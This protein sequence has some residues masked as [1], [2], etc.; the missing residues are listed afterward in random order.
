M[1][2][3]YPAWWTA[4]RNPAV[5]GHAL[6][7]FKPL[8]EISV[9]D[10]PWHQQDLLALVE[11]CTVWVLVTFVTV[12][13]A[14]IFAQ[15]GVNLTHFVPPLSSD[16]QHLSYGDCPE[17]R[18]EIMRTVLCCIVYW[19]LYTVI[20]TLRWAVLTV[21]WIGFCLTGPISL[22]V[23]SCVYIF[24]HCI[25]LL[26]MCCIIVTRWGRPGKIEA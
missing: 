22:C 15:I 1:P 2:S 8:W 14:D 10:N 9:C 4:I 23:D 19:K 25:V 11:V 7:W 21:L 13:T 20:S 26:H 18:E 17:G 16:R 3:V 24:L 6:Q 12:P 5:T